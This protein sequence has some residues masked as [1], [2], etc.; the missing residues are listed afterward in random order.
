MRTAE[1]SD[2]SYDMTSLDLVNIL[3]PMISTIQQ[4]AIRIWFLVTLLL[5]LSH[6]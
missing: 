2:K 3:R 1:H 4:V 5:I 6:N